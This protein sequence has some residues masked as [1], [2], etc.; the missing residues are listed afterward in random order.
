MCRRAMISS[1]WEGLFEDWLKN[2][3]DLMNYDWIDFC[4]YITVSISY[5]SLKFIVNYGEKGCL[6]LLK[7][8]GWFAFGE[9]VSIKLTHVDLQSK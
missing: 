5:I 9:I 2:E 4:S 7:V 1:T 3:I 8:M 6:E